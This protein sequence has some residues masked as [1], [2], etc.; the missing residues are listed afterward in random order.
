MKITAVLLASALLLPAASAFAQSFS[1]VAP[2]ADLQEL[3]G[4]YPAA[5]AAAPTAGSATYFGVVSTHDAGHEQ[6]GR[7]RQALA[8][9]QATVILYEKPDM[10]VD[11]TEAA[12]IER[13]GEGGYVRFLAQQHGLPAERFDDP[14]AEYAY[15]RS[16]VE[17]TPLKLY[18][19]LEASRQFRKNT[20]ASNALM[21]KAM[22]QLIQNSA[23]FVPGTEQVIRNLA[24]FEAAYRQYYPAGGAW[25]QHPAADTDAPAPAGRPAAAFAQAINEHRRTFR[26]QR[27]SQQLAAKVQAG[28]R[29]LVVLDHRHLPTPATYAVG[30]RASR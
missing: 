14:A 10:G 9:S 20:G 11:S 7:L 3:A 26:A 22:K 8:A 24:E 15:L 25:W 5:K 6:F 12:T 23:A 13:L 2:T 18:Y 29:V 27:L 19:L 4:C 1:F 16:R 21:V 17:P 28:E 30:T